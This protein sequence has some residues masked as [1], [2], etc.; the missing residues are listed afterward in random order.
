MSLARREAISWNL[1]RV[2]NLGER[3]TFRTISMMQNTS[4]R[5]GAGEA[6]RPA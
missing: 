4:S 5:P 3:G 2:K 1:F 6:R